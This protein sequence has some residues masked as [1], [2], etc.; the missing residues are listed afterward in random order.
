MPSKL[1]IALA[2]T[3][4]SQFDPATITFIGAVGTLASSGDYYAINN[5]VTDLKLNGLWDKM[6][7][8]YPFIGDTATPNSYNLKNPSQYQLTFFGGWTHT[9]SGALPN[10]SNAYATTGYTYADATTN[11][12]HL[13]YYS[14]TDSTP[15]VGQGGDPVEIGNAT[16][17]S[18]T[19]IEYNLQVRSSGNLSY[20]R[21]YSDPAQ[22]GQING[23][24]VT[25]N[26]NS[27]GFY[28]GSRTS[29]TSHKLYK[30]GLQIGSTNTTA[31][32]YTLSGAT[33]IQ[34]A[35]GNGGSYSNRQVAFA[36]IG[37]GLTDAQVLTLTSIVQRYQLLQGRNIVAVPAVQDLDAQNFLMAAQIT[38][39]TQASAVQNLTAGLKYYSLWSKMQAAYP[40]VGGTST[41]QKF[42]LKSPYDADASFRLTFSGGWTH[43]TNG[44]LPNGTNGF[45]NTFYIPNTS[46][47]Q[48]NAHAS[49][50][51]RTNTAAN[52][53]DFGASQGS[54]TRQT[55]IGARD[56]SNA[57][58]WG[59]NS[60][61]VDVG[62]Q[63]N[64]QGLWTVTR[65]DATSVLG[66]K[67]GTL[68]NT[69]ALPSTGQNTVAYYISAFNNN[70][71]AAQFSNRQVAFGS[72]GT[73]LSGT[74]LTNLYTVVQAY[75]TELSR[76]V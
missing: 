28:I 44:A 61:S 63:A 64:S 51:L 34:L 13:S 67:N 40:F 41:T 9:S 73:G 57:Q 17:P 71:T 29:S 36:S 58:A 10:G 65:S 70:G 46:G 22:P 60:G 69:N 66:Y 59:L 25:S 38:D 19:V 2:G 50:Y 72:I 3:F 39:S 75:Q 20:S 6:D 14:R 23:Q 43:S 4:D 1:G 74:D 5:L 16:N 11:D 18:P 37:K 68:L 42:N 33:A 76:Q 48:N 26:T 27:Q 35:K 12:T 24:I 32:S 7:A 54:P 8:I 49:L 15:G 30:N 31:N 53:K 52:V 45:A 62:N 56:A 21:Q 47:S 55:Y